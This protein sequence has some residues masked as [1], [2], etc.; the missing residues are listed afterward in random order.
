MGIFKLKVNHFAV[1]SGGG[2]HDRFAE[3]GVGVHGFD[4]FMTGTFELA[5][6]NQFS[7]HFRNIRPNHVGAEYFPVFG[8]KNQFN[9]AVFVPGGAGFAGGTH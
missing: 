8:I 5:G 2:F 9:E 1:G 6:Q 4:E 7:D 3:G